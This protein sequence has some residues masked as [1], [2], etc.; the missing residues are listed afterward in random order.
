MKNYRR[1][2][3]YNNK[4]NQ[5]E[6]LKIPKYT[7]SINL[8]NLFGSFSNEKLDRSTMFKFNILFIRILEY[9]TYSFTNCLNNE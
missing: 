5:S 2:L 7:L 3:Q 8:N 9:I 4:L 1:N 6:V